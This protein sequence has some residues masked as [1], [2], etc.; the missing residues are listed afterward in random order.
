MLFYQNDILSSITDEV[1]ILG[2]NR[3]TFTT[4]QP[5]WESVPKTL[6]CHSSL[7]CKYQENQLRLVQ[8]SVNPLREM[9][10]GKQASGLCDSEAQ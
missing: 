1:K 2:D 10:E 6:L 4:D 8:S 9:P 7:C 3:V 5:T